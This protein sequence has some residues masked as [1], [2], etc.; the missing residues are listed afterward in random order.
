MPA[1]LLL[2]SDGR[3]P[4]G[5]HVHSGGLEAAVAAGRVEDVCTLGQFLSGRLGTA[6]LCAAGLAAAAC[7]GRHGWRTLDAEADARTPSPAQRAASRKQ[8][9]ALVRVAAR[10]WP[11]E[12]LRSLCEQVPQ[13]HHPV[14][15]GAAA[16]AAELGA[17]DAALASAYSSVAGPASAAVRLL[18]LDPL[19]VA[20]LLATL[21]PRIDAIASQ[22]FAASRGPLRALPS[23]TAPLLE[24]DAELHASWEVRLFAS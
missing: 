9:R 1:R 5:G 4:G 17:Q 10:A 11:G 14:A 18:G 23:Q 6:G 2:L 8:G 19:A 3:F 24:I 21:G 15:L 7:T 22:A 16:A 20:A 13:P 12:V